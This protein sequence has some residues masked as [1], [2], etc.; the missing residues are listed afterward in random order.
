[1]FKKLSKKCLYRKSDQ[2]QTKF[3]ILIKSGQTIY[4]DYGILSGGNGDFHFPLMHF[5]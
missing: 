4:V 1:M 2:I 3:S 5:A